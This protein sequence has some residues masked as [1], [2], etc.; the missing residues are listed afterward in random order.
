MEKKEERKKEMNE[1]LFSNISKR[2]AKCTIISDLEK[3]KN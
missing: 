3:L 2:N 1:N